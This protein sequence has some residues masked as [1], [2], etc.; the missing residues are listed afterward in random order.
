MRSYPASGI[1]RFS[2]CTIDCL[3]LQGRYPAFAATEWHKLTQGEASAWSNDRQSLSIH[4]LTGYRKIILPRVWGHFKQFDSQPPESD[5]HLRTPRRFYHRPRSIDS[6][7]ETDSNLPRNPPPHLVRGT[8]TYYKRGERGREAFECMDAGDH[9]SSRTYSEPSKLEQHQR[10]MFRELSD[11]PSCSSAQRP[12]RHL[13]ATRSPATMTHFL[14][15]IAEDAIRAD[16]IAQKLVDH[17]LANTAGA[18]GCLRER[19]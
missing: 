2:F 13:R 9:I 12:P 15:A 5:R 18:L 6:A 8:V 14:R 11:V 3:L 4:N 16:E 1:Q 10:Q 17:M 7:I 19:C